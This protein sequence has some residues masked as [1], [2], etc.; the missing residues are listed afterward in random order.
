MYC[1]LFI[2]LSTDVH[3]SCFHLLA[4]VNHA[5]VNVGVQISESLFST[6]VKERSGIAGLYGKII[7]AI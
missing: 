5:T 4:I 2:H 3:L 6:L 1:I 7:F